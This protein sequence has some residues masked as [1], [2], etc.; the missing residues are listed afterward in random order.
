MRFKSLEIE[1][2]KAITNVT[3]AGLTD[4]VL[5]AGPNGCGKSCIFDA[6]R[7]LKSVYGGY[8]ANEVQNFFSEFQLN[9]RVDANA[10]MRLAQDRAKPIR[11]SAEITL[12]K[13]ETKWLKQNAETLVRELAWK[14]Q[15][16]D[17]ASQ[18][19]DTSSLASQH[20]I[21]HR[22]IEKKIA[23]DAPALITEL[24]KAGFSGEVVIEPNSRVSVQDSLALELIFSKYSP[25]NLGVID[26]HGPQRTY[27]REQFGGLNINLDALEQQSSQTAL[28]NYVNKYQNVK[29]QLAASYVRELIAKEAGGSGNVM[30]DLNATL[31]ELFALFFPNKKF[32]G[33]QPTKDGTLLFDVQTKC[34]SSHDINE[35]SSGEKEILYGYLRLRNSSLR[36]SV[37]LIDEP[38]LH[39]N[40]KLAYGLPDF[41]HRHL[42]TALENQLWLVT[43]SDALLRASVGNPAFKIFHMQEA[44]TIPVGQNQVQEISVTEELDKGVIALVGDLAAYRPGKKLVIVEGG[45]ESEFDETILTKLFPDFQGQVNLISTGSKAK[46]RALHEVLDQAKNSGAVPFGFFSIVD[47][48]ADSP[49][50]NNPTNRFKWDRYHIENY[51]LEPKYVLK[52]V[53]VVEQAKTDNYTEAKILESLRRA[54]R[55]TL[56]GLV[57]FQLEDFA[58]RQLTHCIRTNSDR[59][60]AKVS[61]TLKTAIQETKA[62]LDAAITDELSLPKLKAREGDITQKLRKDLQ[63]KRWLTNFKGRDVLKAFVADFLKGKVSY[64]I[65]RNMIIN[66][67]REDE[68][69][70]RGMKVVLDKIIS[71]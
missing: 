19:I 22:Q 12:S 20:R 41:Y 21:H 63:S 25:E 69:E 4:V 51:L 40:P 31:K 26:F 68:F 39:L 13:E 57:R 11:I 44:G 49:T 36:R 6:L 8:Q 2:F 46:V 30:E 42:G 47:K 32:L 71:V 5:I 50:V 33:T 58:N 37:I 64:E 38:E 59:K 27:N 52:A 16:P 60:A 29:T 28:Y 35:L 3:L 61:P 43:H 67:M 1:N 18:V 62:R 45:G 56:P 55:K 34:G 17:I 66:A 15:F 14:S 10:L 7:L 23:M 48:D 24:G 65:F 9:T 54:A 53:R 70:P